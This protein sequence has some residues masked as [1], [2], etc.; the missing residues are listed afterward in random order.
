MRRFQFF[1]KRVWKRDWHP[2]DVLIPVPLD[3]KE[4]LVWWSNRQRLEKGLSLLHKEPD[5]LL[6][7]D[8][9]RERWGATLNHIHLSGQWSKEEAREHIN[10][11]ELRAILYALKS[12]RDQVEN[13]IVGVFADNTTALSYIR[14]Q[15]GTKSWELFQLVEELFAWLELHNVT[16]IPRFVQGKSNVVADTLSRKDKVIPTEWTLN[17]LVC[18]EL[19]REWGRPLVD[20]FATSLTKRLPMY[21][22][23]HLDPMALGV[24]AF[25]QS[26]ENLEVYAFPPFVLIRKVINKFRR[27]KNCRMTLVA[28][29][30][31]QREWFP[32]VIE[33]LVEI[34]RSLPQ[35]KDLLTQPA[36]RA[37]HQGLHTLRLTG[38]RLSS[39][40]EERRIFQERY[41]GEFLELGQSP[42]M[43]Y[44]R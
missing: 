39:V 30:W 33:L 22:A 32:D 40:W 9:S 35:R 44:T 2:L 14:K 38:W 15:G 18:K 28:P 16:L 21:F 3:L 43:P 26:W 11:L 20:L 4:S 5:L 17:A 10:K 37:L 24:D 25:L 23:P 42:L 27:T 12:M 36:S 6:F 29:W 7:T 8:A 34:P 41:Q 31:P 19:W 1:L 13:K